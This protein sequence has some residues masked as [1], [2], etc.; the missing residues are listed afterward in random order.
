MIKSKTVIK[1]VLRRAKRIIHPPCPPCPLPHAFSQEGEDLILGRVFEAKPEGF[2]VDVGAHH[3]TPYSNTY[4]FYLRGWRGINIDA[5]PGSMTAFKAGRPRDIN[6]EIA[7]A[8]NPG[9]LTYHIFNDPAL[10]TFD[11]ALAKERDGK[12]IYK[13]IETK[14]I[15]MRP[16]AQILSEHIPAQETIDFMSVDVE[17]FDLPVV[18]S[19][20]WERFSPK[21]VLA[22]DFSGETVEEALNSPIA[23]Y[24][25]SL[26]YLLFGKTAHTQ[27]F[28]RK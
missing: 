7:V 10:N 22:E 25:R 18:R 19:N 1:K 3:P 4:Y 14:E 28:R 13:I 27:I 17:G 12:D 15:E 24:L 2:Y 9:K 21:Y 8:E 11:P 6:L 5:M 20:D 26:G 23:A 16:L